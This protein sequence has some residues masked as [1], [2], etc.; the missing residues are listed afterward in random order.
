MGIIYRSRFFLSA[1]TKTS[2]Y[3]TLIYPYL[4]YCTIVWSSTYVTNLN[5][6]FL[7]QKRAVRAITNSDFRAHSAPL[8]A[9][10]NILDIFQVNSLYVAKFMFSYHHRLLPSPF[11]NLFLSNSQIHNYDTR[12]SAQL[13][14]HACRTNIKRFTILYQGPKIWNAL[15]SSVTF[16]PSL[17]S[18]KKKFLHLFKN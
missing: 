2:L 15:P 5:C 10:L 8:F 11:L 12:A 7:L 1:K 9:Q 6:I 4:T 18:F 3:Y 13:R 17:S 16:S 14:P